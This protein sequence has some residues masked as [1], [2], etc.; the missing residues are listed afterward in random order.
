MADFATADDVAALR[1]LSDAEMPRVTVLLGYASAYIRQQV[2]GIDARITAST[3]DSSLPRMVT[4]MA[5]LRGLQQVA[6][7]PGAKSESTTTG[8]YTHSVT[9]AE[10]VGSGLIFISDADLTSLQAVPTS[11]ASAGVGTIR[12][13]PGFSLGCGSGPSRYGW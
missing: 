8:P 9:Y 12:L 1:P 11:T 3:L 5:V 2:P 4:V 6:A 13:L 7:T 10:A